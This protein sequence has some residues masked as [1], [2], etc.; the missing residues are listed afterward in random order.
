MKTYQGPSEVDA[1]CAR[2]GAVQPRRLGEAEEAVGGHA[3]TGLKF[4]VQNFGVDE[5]AALVRRA[6]RTGV[7]S[8]ELGRV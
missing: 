8:L 2:V 7:V 4:E 5:T 6:S 1:R 3:G